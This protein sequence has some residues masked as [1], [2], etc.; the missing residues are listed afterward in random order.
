MGPVGVLLRAAGIKPCNGS[1]VLPSLGRLTFSSLPSFIT[2]LQTPVVTS[3]YS[4]ESRTPNTCWTQGMHEE[5]WD[6]IDRKK[7]E[8][9]RDPCTA[10][11]LKL[12]DRGKLQ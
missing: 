10:I 6:Y 4:G 5:G 9:R 2:G 11:H 12:F 8:L 7:Q 1:T 3:L